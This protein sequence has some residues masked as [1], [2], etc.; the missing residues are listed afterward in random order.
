MHKD[1]T[2]WSKVYT[3]FK[4]R[5]K[6]SIFPSAQFFSQPYDIQT[7][8]EVYLEK[9]RRWVTLGHLIWA[10]KKPVATEQSVCQSWWTAFKIVYIVSSSGAVSYTHLDVYKRQGEAITYQYAI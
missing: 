5:S 6:W 3:D 1:G 7:T 2:S 8:Y 9:R 4:Q 10:L